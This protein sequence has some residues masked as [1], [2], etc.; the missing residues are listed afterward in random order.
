MGWSWS[1]VGMEYGPTWRKYRG[2][3][4]KHFR[5]RVVPV[6][7]PIEVKGVRT[8]L[9]NFNR[10]PEDFEKHLHRYGFSQS[11]SDLYSLNNQFSLL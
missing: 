4:E 7:K 2:L 3:F 5:S 11:T 1:L 8:L 9:Q 10:S 6:Y